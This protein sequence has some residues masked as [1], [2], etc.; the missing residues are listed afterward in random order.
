MTDEDFAAAQNIKSQ[1][2]A[3]DEERLIWANLA[4]ADGNKPLRLSIVIDGRTM[5]YTPKRVVDALKAQAVP[6]LDADIAA[7][8]QDF[9]AL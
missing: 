7:L 1:I 2:A 5:V 9:A 8:E 4:R 3:I 6:G